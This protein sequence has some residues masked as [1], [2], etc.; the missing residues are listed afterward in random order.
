MQCIISPLGDSMKLELTHKDVYKLALQTAIHIQQYVVNNGLKNIPLVVYAVP[1]GGI[2]A[3]YLL[4]NSVGFHITDNPDNAHIIVDDLIDSG[5]TMKR[6]QKEYPNKPFF[7][8]IDKRHDKRFHGRWI[9]FPWESTDKK[10]DTSGND[11]VVRLLQLVGENPYREGLMETPNRVVKA[12]RHWCSGYHKDAKEILK[13]FEDGAEGCDQMVVRKD[14]PIHS[15]CEH[16]LAAIIGKCTIAYVPRGKVVGLSKLDRLADMFARRLQ[17]QERM[18]NQIAD[19]LVDNL[20]PIGVG[21]WI[22]ARHLCVESRGVQH[23]N[24]ETI[25]SALR[26]CIRDQD[27]SRAEFLALARS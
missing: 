17:V 25:T 9:I 2:P 23:S 21:V 11:I 3:A 19:A 14:I 1:R 12:W 10:A 8:L 6:Y 16:H 7:A 24:S 18:T 20:D 27:A 15:H 22:S 5:S 4:R 13:V 26:G